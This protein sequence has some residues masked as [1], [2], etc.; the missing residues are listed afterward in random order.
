M[1]RL[2]SEPPTKRHKSDVAAA[3]DA[4]PRRGLGTAAATTAV[5]SSPPRRFQ[6]ASSPS[7]TH[8]I[9]TLEARLAHTEAQLAQMHVMLTQIMDRLVPAAPTAPVTDP[10]AYMASGI[11]GGQDELPDLFS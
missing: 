1:P 8:E 6:T 11:E 4:T 5:Q 2:F 10:D 3:G 9:A 7:S